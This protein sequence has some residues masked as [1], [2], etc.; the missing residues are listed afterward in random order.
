MFVCC[1]TSLV[2]HKVKRII[3]N[4]LRRRRILEQKAAEYII[5]EREQMKDVVTIS[6]LRETVFSKQLLAV[7]DLY[8][9]S[10]L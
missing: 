10:E 9:V 3:S 5:A 2:W 8:T 4:S 7:S 1:Q 6:L